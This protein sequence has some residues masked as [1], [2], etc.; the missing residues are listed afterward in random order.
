[1]FEYQPKPPYPI[2]MIF[3]SSQSYNPVSPSFSVN[4]L[5]NVIGASVLWAQIPFSHYVIDRTCNEFEVRAG[6]TATITSLPWTKILLKPGTY[7]PKDFEYQLREA[8]SNTAIENNVAFN[9]YMDRHTLRLVIYNT[10]LEITESFQFRCTNKILAKILG[11]GEGVEYVSIREQLWRDGTLLNSGAVMEYIEFPGL[12]NL[13][14][15]TYMII[16]SSLAENMPGFGKALNAQSTQLLNMPILGNFGSVLHYQGSG[17]MVPCD[18]QTIS[19]VE[20]RII[21]P[22]RTEYAVNNLLPDSPIVT[23]NS[24]NLNG[25]PFVICIRFWLDYNIRS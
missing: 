3:D 12:L 22:D 25:L 24:I 10:G 23:Q 5:K 19:N 15:N 4:S 9:A 17:V 1:M 18:P 13:Q 11:V 20:I 7:S 6:T 14:P 21:L 2:D 8:F 16:E